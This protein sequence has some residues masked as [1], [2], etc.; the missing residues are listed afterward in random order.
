MTIT[1]TYGYMYFLEPDQIVNNV[2]IKY[3]LV[4]AGGSNSVAVNAAAKNVA[5]EDDTANTHIAVN[6]TLS[7]AISDPN[8]SGLSG[9]YTVVG[10]GKQPLDGGLGVIVKDGDGNFYFLTNVEYK[11]PDK[12]FSEQ[13]NTSTQ[14]L[15]TPHDL[16]MTCFLVGTT[17]RTSS[18]EVAVENSESRRSRADFRGALR[19]G[20]MDRSPNCFASFW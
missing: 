17:I 15:P 8:S 3:D 5:I 16:V 4:D 14:T 1:G 19:T 12:I 9:D 11:G 7:V 18:G 6:D 10:A 13:V 20:A 2:P